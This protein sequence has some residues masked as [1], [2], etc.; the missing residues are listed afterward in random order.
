MEFVAHGEKSAADPNQHKQHRHFHP[1]DRAATKRAPK[2]SRQNSVLGDVSG[3]PNEEL[4]MDKRLR[5]N[6][7]IQPAQDRPND[8]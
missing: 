7:R 3:F 1:P 2:E 5:R 6:A 8:S 4:N